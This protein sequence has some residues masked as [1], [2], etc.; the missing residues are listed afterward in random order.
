MT[1]YG[2][3][4]TVAFCAVVWPT[5]LILLARPDAWPILLPMLA[6][7]AVALAG[8]VA[9]WDRRAGHLSLEIGAL[10]I[11]VVAL[12]L[13]YPIAAYIANGLRFTPYNDGRLWQ[14]QPTPGALAEV[15]WYYVLHLAAFV[16]LYLWSRRGMMLPR[17]PV[18]IRRG[19]VVALLVLYVAVQAFFLAIGQFYDL[20]AESYIESYL[21]SRRLP[22]V[23]AQIYSHLNGIKL[24]LEIALLIVLFS[25]Y[26]RYR[27]IIAAWLGV[28]ALGTVWQLGQR[29]GLVLMVLS[30]ALLY[31]GMVRPISLRRLALVGAFGLMAFVLLGQLRGGTF[32]VHDDAGPLWAR[33]TEFENALANAYDLRQRGIGGLPL[34]FHLA[35][36]I[37]IPQ[38]L[39]PFEKI[40]PATWY[41]STFFRDYY[42][43]G[44]GLAFG[45][46]AQAVVG[47][48]LLD[49][50]ARG[51]ILGWL[52]GWLHR[53]TARHATAL[54]AIVAYIWCSVLI[55][56]AFRNTTFCLLPMFLYRLLPV[57]LAVTALVAL[58]PSRQARST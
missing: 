26:R 3:R 41:V 21:V 42:D 28:I 52:L 13:L 45:V 53:A 7:V 17:V 43:A 46:V 15:A 16:A 24:V 11:A 10:Y 54:W 23:L 20:R 18:E 6:M 5:A 51:A 2:L 27:W 36:L 39:L 40:D 9:L 34:S 58:A 14:K 44:G 55:Y 50:M 35:D 1:R 8:T 48:G 57:V 22:L 19:T 47:G 37:V 49:V 30:T 56:N 4:A 29:T 12:Y 38:Q 32:E 25:H 31:H 33:A